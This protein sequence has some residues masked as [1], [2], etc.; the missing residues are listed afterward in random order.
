[1]VMDLQKVGRNTLVTVG[2]LTILSGIGTFFGT[3]DPLFQE[4]GAEHLTV[5]VAIMKLIIGV[6]MLVNVT[7]LIGALVAV[8]YYGG[9]AAT[10]TAFESYNVQFA[11]VIILT[12]ALW[13]GIMAKVHGER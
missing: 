3:L 9:A 1:M 12:I 5:L 13:T 11:V 6:L 2:V 8:S 10:H 7:R 4:W